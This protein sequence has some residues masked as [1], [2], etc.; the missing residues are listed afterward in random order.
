MPRRSKSERL[1]AC[2]LRNLCQ[3]RPSPVQKHLL[4]SSRQECTD[5][6]NEIRR[7]MDNLLALPR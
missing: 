4:W 1:E 2:N 6:E 5:M 7:H 3:G